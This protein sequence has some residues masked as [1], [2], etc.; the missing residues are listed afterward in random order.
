MLC[1]F[2]FSLKFSNFPCDFFSLAYGLFRSALF[3]LLIF[4]DFSD[5]F[6]KVSSLIL[7]WPKKRLYM[8]SIHY[9]ILRLVLWP[10]IWSILVS[11]LYAPEGSVYCAVV[12][13]SVLIMSGQEG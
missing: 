9:N 5:I 4:E 3:N 7:L 12:G 10:R 1:S 8:I 13:W 2:L 11:Y 6:F